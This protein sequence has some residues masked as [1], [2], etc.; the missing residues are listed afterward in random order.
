MTGCSNS[1][2]R[3]LSTWQSAQQRLSGANRD[4]HQ[5]RYRHA[6]SD[7][8]DAATWH[9]CKKPRGFLL[10]RL[11]AF[12]GCNAPPRAAQPRFKGSL[13]GSE[14]GR[15]MVVASKRVRLAVLSQANEDSNKVRCIKRRRGAR[16]Q[17]RL[18]VSDEQNS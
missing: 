18:D 11:G 8:A 14:R 1:C 2:N 17:R 10:S 15:R 4:H 6:A 9:H 5:A 3:I 16:Q 7:S 13:R 12:F